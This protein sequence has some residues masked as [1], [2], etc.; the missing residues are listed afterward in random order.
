ME[1]LKGSYEFE[2]SSIP[3]EFTIQRCVFPLRQLTVSSVI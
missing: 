2:L 1:A 3:C